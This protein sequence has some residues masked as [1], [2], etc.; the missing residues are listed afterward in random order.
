MRKQEGVDYTLMANTK[1]DENRIH[2]Y[3]HP[4]KL[5]IGAIHGE[6]DWNSFPTIE[7]VKTILKNQQEFFRD[8]I[9]N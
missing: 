7:N 5:I 4:D 3:N 1:S 2:I 8:K 6:N 9:K